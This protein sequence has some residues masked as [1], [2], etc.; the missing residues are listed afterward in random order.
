MLSELHRDSCTK[1]SLPPLHCCQQTHGMNLDLPPDIRGLA[2][3][4]VIQLQTAAK[5]STA[6]GAKTARLG[7]VGL[8]SSSQLEKLHVMFMAA[9]Q[10]PMMLQLLVLLLRLRRMITNGSCCC[11]AVCS[12]TPGNADPTNTSLRCVASLCTLMQSTP[13]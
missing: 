1:S 8:R 4:H 6:K 10:N 2:D 11:G 13:G 12:N 3:L 9:A 7:P 5:A